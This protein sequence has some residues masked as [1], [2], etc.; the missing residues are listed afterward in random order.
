[1]EAEKKLI[2]QLQQETNPT[3]EYDYSTIDIVNDMRAPEKDKPY[4]AEDL[5][6]A[7]VLYTDKSTRRAMIY[8][9]IHKNLRVWYK[10]L[11]E[12]I[13]RLEIEEYS[14]YDKKWKKIDQYGVRL[15]KEK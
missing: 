15:T 10:N 2:G 3:N 7:T 6:H 13:F 4:R 14:F 12:G 8:F 5:E 11:G 1:M 9:D